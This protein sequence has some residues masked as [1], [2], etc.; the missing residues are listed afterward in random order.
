PGGAIARKSRVSNAGIFT[1]NSSVHKAVLRALL[2][3]ARPGEF[4]SVKALLDGGADVNQ[5]GSGDGTTALLIATIDWQ[6]DLAK[7]LLDHGADPG[8]SSKNGVTALY[9]VL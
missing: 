1:T 6:F 8:V 4:E 9:A 2:F 5:P 3:A 7:F